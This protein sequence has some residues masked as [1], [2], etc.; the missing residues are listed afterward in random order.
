MIKRLIDRLR[1]A[2]RGW[3]REEDAIRCLDVTIDREILRVAASRAVGLRLECTIPGRRFACHLLIDER[4]AVDRDQFWRLWRR[5][6][7]RP[8]KWADGTLFRPDSD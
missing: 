8:M 2:L 1:R 3:L 7:G 4:Q 6:G 5:F